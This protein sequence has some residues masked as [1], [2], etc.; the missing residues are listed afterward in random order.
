MDIARW[1]IPEQ[2]GQKSIFCVGGRFGYKDQGETANTQLAI[3]DY[4][5][6]CSSLMSWPIRQIEYGCF[7]PGLFQ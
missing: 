2:F 5:N 4:G 7:Q 3:F 6:L 1:M